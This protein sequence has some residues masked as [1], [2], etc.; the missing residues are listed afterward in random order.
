MTWHN[1]GVKWHN[2]ETR[3]LG[4]RSHNAEIRSIFEN[5]FARGLF[6]KKVSK[7][8]QIAK[9]SRS[10]YSSSLLT[11][12]FGPTLVAGYLTVGTPPPLLLPCHSYPNPDDLPP[13]SY[14]SP[15]PTPPCPLA[16]SLAN[17]PP[18]AH[19]CCSFLPFPNSNPPATKQLSP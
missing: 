6:P 1:L 15:P 7:K 16:I 13:L 5:C 2:A 19:P 17:S 12:T 14:P 8:G 9:I 3:I 11:A 4:V 10:S 18:F